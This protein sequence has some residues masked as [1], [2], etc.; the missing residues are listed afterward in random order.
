MG[1]DPSTTSAT[2]IE[3]VAGDDGILG[4]T[5]HAD[6]RTAT[7]AP[8]VESLM[9]EIDVYIVA[10][11][12]THGALYKAVT[13]IRNQAKSLKLFLTEPAIPIHNNLSERALRIVA[14]LPKNSLFAG[15]D[16][17]A[18]RYAQLLSLLT[19]C[20]LHDVDSQRWLAD[21]LIE[22]QRP[23]AGRVAEDLLPWN[24]KRERGKLAKPLVDL[25]E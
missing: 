18:Q 10:A 17:A 1:E 3:Q 20:R 12:D 5:A 4:T 7:S 6:R 14:L 9:S 15:H 21:V 16:E 13:Y 2:P 22:V 25:R 8:V 24:W 19:T 23:V 11:L